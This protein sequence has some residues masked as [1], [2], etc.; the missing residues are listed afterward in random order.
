[1][2]LRQLMGHVSGIRNDGGDEGP[3]L[4]THCERIAEALPA[5]AERPLLFEPGTKYRYSSYGWILVSAAVEA[6]AA[7]S[8]LTFMQ[9]QIFE[10]LKMDDTVA[11]SEKASI[12]TRATP[13]FPR[14]AANPRYGPDVMRPIEYSCYSGASVFLSTPSDLVRFG[15]AINSGTL[16]RPA[17]VDALQTS[18]RLSSGQ[19]TGRGLGWNLET[20]MF[21]GRDTR[22]AGSDGTSL[23]GPVVSLRIVRDPRIVVAVTSNI[24][25]A[26]TSALALAV[27]KAFASAIR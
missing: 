23:G 6:A 7:H 25:Y 3:L 8:L 14:Y 24:S 19:E 1:V 5:F 18:Q 2:T 22:V 21:A 13:Y 12:P 26:D 4:G 16:L 15:M 11:D 10:P 27:A 17:T 20:A 9:E